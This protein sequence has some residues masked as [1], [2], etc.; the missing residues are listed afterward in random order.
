MSKLLSFGYVEDD[1]A[2]I[3]LSSK[4][5]GVSERFRYNLPNHR[6]SFPPL[7][8]HNVLKIHLTIIE[9][10]EA[11]GVNLKISTTENLRCFLTV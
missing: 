3:G 8:F 5:H 1:T 10:N 9:G 7:F 11:T 6:E 4:S 2:A